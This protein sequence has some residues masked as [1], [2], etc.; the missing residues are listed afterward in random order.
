[1][2]EPPKKRAKTTKETIADQRLKKWFPEQK[3]RQEYLTFHSTKEVMR[4]HFINL[5]WFEKAGFQFSREF[6]SQGLGTFVS[7]SGMYYPELV[8]V[9]Y[10][11]LRLVMMGSLGQELMELTWLLMMLSGQL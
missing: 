2:A 1:M 5:E 10:T 7:L 8:K 3:L 9:F 11:C 6:S 4:P